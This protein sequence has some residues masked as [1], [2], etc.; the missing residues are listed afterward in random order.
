MFL[1]L[2]KQSKTI[3]NNQNMKNMKN[4]KNQLIKMLLLA[5]ILVNMPINGVFAQKKYNEIIA[6]AKT[7]MAENDY[8]NAILLLNKAIESKPKVAE[9]HYLKGLCH[10]FIS[11][12]KE[13]IP[14]Y[15]EA[16]RLDNKKWEY[17]KRRGDVLYNTKEHI[18]SLPDYLKAIELEPTKKNDTLF[19]YLA[20]NYRMLESPQNFQLAIDNYDKAI[21]INNNNPKMYF[22]RA[23]MHVQL[24]NKEKACADYKKAFEIGE[25]NINTSYEYDANKYYV[26]KTEAYS[27]LSCEWAKPP[28]DNSPVGV[29]NVE[30]VP[31]TGTIITSKGF[32][33]K[34]LEISPEIGGGFVTSAVFAY[35]DEINIKVLKPENLSIGDN[36]A[37]IG[38]GFAVFEGAKELFKQE[39]IFES[40][41]V[42]DTETL[43]SLTLSIKFDKL[44]S[45]AKTYTLKT[46]FFDN[47]SNKMILLDMPFMLADSTS[48]ANSVNNTK[49]TIADGVNTS[50]VNS[51]EI[52]KIAFLVANKPVA[53]LKSNQKPNQKST[54]KSSVFLSETKNFSD[55]VVV[56]YSFV[57]KSTGERTFLSDVNPLVISTIASKKGFNIL[58][59]TPQTQ[60][61]YIL[62]VEVKD[63][64][65]KN[66]I[67]C[68]SYPISVE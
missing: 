13:A 65:D 64:K 1:V 41:N 39:N 3:K 28:K 23:Y 27:L 58:L 52:K 24:K 42:F 49:N 31:F 4:M 66:K 12:E 67:W 55:N 46:K 43:K 2:K 11:K 51:V 45:V 26:A 61:N 20:D 16:I 57:D 37:Y 15:D 9:N 56:R 17:F 32:S 25:K 7:K 30:V 8:A 33:Y 48:K 62:W 10:Y 47:R 29:T 63:K 18:K 14:F 40:N 19:Q 35:D 60:G 21:N 50:A 59:E 6:S 68:V 36:K 44:L 38:A 54:Q 53:M 22:D 34:E 5:F